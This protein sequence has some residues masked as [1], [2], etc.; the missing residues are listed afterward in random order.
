MTFSHIEVLWSTHTGSMFIE[1]GKIQIWEWHETSKIH[2]RIFNSE[3]GTK[4]I[5]RLLPVL[6][7]WQTCQRISWTIFPGGSISTIL[8]KWEENAALKTNN[9]GHFG[10]IL[11]PFDRLR[12]WALMGLKPQPL[13]IHFLS[14]AIEIALP[15]KRELRSCQQEFLGFKILAVERGFRRSRRT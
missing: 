3:P 8:F 9:G 2:Q 13:G 1:Y 12:A 15:R 6:H 4:L 11:D 14:K 7:I 10:K 5:L